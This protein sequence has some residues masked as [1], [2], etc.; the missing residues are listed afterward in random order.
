MSKERDL[1]FPGI[2]APGGVWAELGSGSGIFTLALFETAGPAIELYSVDRDAKALDKQRHAIAQ[3]Y[4]NAR[5]TYLRADFTQP[6]SL[7]PLDGILMANALHFV[8]FDAQPAAFKQIVS[9]LKPGG[10]LVVVEYDAQRGNFWVPYPLD[11][12]SFQYIA[13]EAGLISIQRLAIIPSSFMNAMYSAIA[14]KPE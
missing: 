8:K 2:P 9:Y 14:L 3:R 13:A 4:P 11:Y 10:K 1:I 6:L 12:E 5:V 7:P